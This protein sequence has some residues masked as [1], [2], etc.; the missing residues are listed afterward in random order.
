MARQHTEYPPDSGQRHP[1]NIE[2]VDPFSIEYFQRL[3]QICLQIN[4]SN[5]EAPA[6]NGHQIDR[7]I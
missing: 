2:G 5:L 1:L 6:G 3:L 7:R 4:G